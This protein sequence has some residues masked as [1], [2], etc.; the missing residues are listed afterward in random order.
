M[1]HH[2][3]RS[4]KTS[5]MRFPWPSTTRRIHHKPLLHVPYVGRDTLL[6]ALEQH[7]QAATAGAVQ[8][9]ALTGPA[10]SGKSSLLTEFTLL[11]CSTPQQL[12]IQLNLSE[13]LL[14]QE[15][16]AQ[17]FAALR[18]RCSKILQALYN[19]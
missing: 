19:E 17:L 3:C 12:L 18:T 15:F 4:H 16:Y 14:V 11:R 7:L 5:T 6:A 13:C 1:W 9:V 2:C 10:G 8:Y